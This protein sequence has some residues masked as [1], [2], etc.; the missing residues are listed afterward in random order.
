MKA[1]LRRCTALA[2]AL[3]LAAAPIGALAQ[4]PPPAGEDPIAQASAHF[5]RGVRLYQE[6]DFRAS[7]IEFNRAYEL[8]P[9][10]AVLC[11]IGQS[12]YQL[13]EY[14]A[15]LKTLEKYVEAGG[16]AIPAERRAQVDREIAEL[17]GRVAHVTL[18]S[19]T[20]GADLTLDDAPLGKT[21]TGEAVVVGAGRH[22]FAASK[23]GFVATSKMVDITGG[24]I[25]TVQLDLIPETPTPAVVRSAPNYTAAIV[26]G[27]VGVAG[28]A[29]G[30]AFGI[31]AI[32]NRSALNKDCDAAKVCPSASQGDINSYS[33]NGTISTVGF[34][35]G[36]VGVAL[37]AYFFFHERGKE[38]SQSATFHPG[39]DGFSLSF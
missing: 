34:G 30:T 22:K 15:A 19:N 1:S 11:N 39:V 7:L 12:Q 16:E 17:R 23:V 21:P 14:P 26:S 20:Q 36:V 2:V 25:L 38:G 35:V 27:A 32:N 37:G 3:A 24:D 28:I 31:M 9:N 8:A 18:A 4:A 10:W 29:V 13:R 33:T 5:Q 6:D